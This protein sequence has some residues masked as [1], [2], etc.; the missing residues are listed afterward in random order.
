[1]RNFSESDSSIYLSLDYLPEN[2]NQP[3]DEN[4]IQVS[5]FW[6]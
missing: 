3:V 4:R 2:T 5:L 1:M 6:Q